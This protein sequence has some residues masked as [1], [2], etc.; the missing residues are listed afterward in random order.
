MVARKQIAPDLLA[1][2]RRLYEQTLAP[3]ADI[4]DMIGLSRSNFYKRVREEGWRGR[5][6]NAGIFRFT[7]ALSGSAVM[8]LTG[9]PAVQPRAEPEVTKDTVSPEQRAALAL[10]IQ[11]IV[12]R[13]MDAVERILANIQP[14]DQLEAEHSARTLAS[15]SRTLREIAALNKPDEAM[16]PDEADD[17]PVPREI[18]EFRREL[19]RRIRGFIEARRNGAGGLSG[20]PQTPLG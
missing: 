15:V 9:E 5:R 6:A 17:D 12:E 8:A 20:E 18:D 14:A 2:A 19:A 1:E 10:R 11:Q 13:E 7:R 16:A 3:V 4:A